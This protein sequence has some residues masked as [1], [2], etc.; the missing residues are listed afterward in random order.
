[1]DKPIFKLG[2]GKGE[3]GVPVNIANDKTLGLYVCSG[4]EEAVG[5]ED[6]TNQIMELN[7]TGKPGTASSLY[8]S[9][10]F[11]LPK[12]GYN[13]VK[14]DEWIEV[15]PTHKEY[16]ERTV[17]SKQALESTIKA[18]LASAAQSVADFELLNHD[19]RKYKEVLDYF[20]KKDEHSLKAMFIDQVDAHTGEGISMRSIAPRWPTLIYHFQ[21]LK[22]EDREPDAIAKKLK[23]SKAEAVILATKN[24]LYE[25][26]KD[27]F[28]NAA[29][30]RYETLLGL[31]EARRKTITEYK[32]WLKPYLARFRMTRLGGERAHIRAASVKSFFDVSGMATFIN[33]VSIWAWK[34][35]KPIDVKRAP[36]EVREGFVI[37]PYDSY[38]REQFILNPYTGL[39]RY[40]PWLVHIRKYCNK[41]KKYY[42][43]ET[44]KCKSCGS[45]LDNRTVADEIIETQIIPM[46]K[47]KE[48]KLDPTALYYVFFDIDV[49]RAGLRLPVGEAEDITFTVKAF[50]ISQNILLVKILE[51]IC[52]ERELERYIDEILGIRSEHK[53]KEVAEL[54]KEDFPNIFK[55]KKEKLTPLDE[56][57]MEWKEVKKK[58]VDFFSKI[59]KVKT[60]EFMFSKPGDYEKDFTD[61]ITKQYL[62]ETG[63]A[64][65]SITKFLKQKMGVS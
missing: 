18:G 19:L 36:A 11:Q 47:A 3:V 50:L 17:A 27:I 29:K 8:Y 20:E 53:E 44:I 9:L 12:W 14:V 52:R 39:A 63:S 42:P 55:V 60:S 26:W 59:K 35:L 38:V 33:G 1:M 32:E 48:L 31:V 25:E 22:P 24:K 37:Y 51:L 43:A 62:T 54:V 30:S 16:Y 56:F 46:W 45:V 5:E 64:F 15:S 58:Y 65:N 21:Q 2:A 23:I 7:F 4:P 49:D 61:R 40:Y 10:V 34:S 41:D 13:V 57:A 6:K 28:L